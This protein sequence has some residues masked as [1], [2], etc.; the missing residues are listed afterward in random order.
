M[1]VLAVT[2]EGRK[3]IFLLYWFLM[4]LF[5]TVLLSRCFMFYLFTQKYAGTGLAMSNVTFGDRST[6]THWSTYVVN[7]LHN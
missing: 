4:L 2:S 6:L 3:V 1:Q 7:E 5:E